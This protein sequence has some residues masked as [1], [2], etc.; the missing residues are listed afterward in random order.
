MGNN[1]SAVAPVKPEQK[2]Q[3]ASNHSKKSLRQGRKQKVRVNTK[4]YTEERVSWGKN[5]SVES[6]KG[7]DKS[8]F[9]DAYQFEISDDEGLD[10]EYYKEPAFLRRQTPL[11]TFKQKYQK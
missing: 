5:T 2:V 10:E 11:Q 1:P 8:P 4:K 3:K 6:S 9:G 7:S